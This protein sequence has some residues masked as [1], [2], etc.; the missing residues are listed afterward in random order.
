[1]GVN[2]LFWFLISNFSFGHNSYFMKITI[3][4]LIFI[5]QYLSNG[6]LGAQFGHHLSLALSSQ[7]S[8]FSWHYNFKMLLIWDS[9]GFLSLH[10]LTLVGVYLNPKTLFC[11]HS[12]FHAL[13]LV[14]SPKLRS[15]HTYPH[16][17][18]LNYLFS[19]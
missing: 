9:F 14:T 2:L 7:N 18:L 10:F 5:L 17:C 12:H 15:W 13:V 1:L 16:T 19:W 11:P 8:K 3:S 6:I 4:L